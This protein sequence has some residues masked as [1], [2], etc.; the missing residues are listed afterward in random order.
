MNFYEVPNI[1]NSKGIDSPTK[2]QQWIYLGLKT[3]K[4]KKDPTDIVY[5]IYT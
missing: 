3:Y 2:Y 1:S 5:L 4:R